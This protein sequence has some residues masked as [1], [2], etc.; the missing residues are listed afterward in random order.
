[1]KQILLA[2]WSSVYAFVYGV[3]GLR[4][5]SRA[6]QMGHGVANG[7]PPLQ[8]FFERSYVAWHDDAEM[9][10]ANLLTCFGVI[11]RD[12]ERF[13]VSFSVDSLSEL[14]N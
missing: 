7:S 3:G 9:G 11:Q 14:I 6:G 13:D 10:L 5:K 2:S 1:M 8:Y 4:F 12:N